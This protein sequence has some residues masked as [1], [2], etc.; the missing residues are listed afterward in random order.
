MSAILGLSMDKKVGL[1]QIFFLIAL[2]IL[3]AAYRDT[4]SGMIE[5]WT[6][7]E[8]YAH[9]FLIYPITLYLIWRR[10]KELAMVPKYWDW[11]ALVFVPFVGVA[12][13]LSDVV[14]VVVVKQ[15]AFTAM[16]PLLVWLVFGWQVLWC[17]AFPLAFLVFA[18][19]MGEGLITPLMNFTAMFT[20][21]LVKWSG[22]PIYAEGTFFSLPSGDWSVVEGCS[23]VRYLIASVTMG[24]LFAYLNYKSLTRRLAFI[25]F[26]IVL[27]II[28]NGLRAYMIVMIAHLSEMKLA[29][30]VDHLIYGWVF[31][32]FIMLLMFWIG[33]YWREEAPETQVDPDQ[34][35]LQNQHKQQSGYLHIVLMLT[36]ILIW[37]YLSH[38]IE[39][40]QGD[41]V[42]PAR[43]ELA[44]SYGGW[45]KTAPFTDWK[46]RYRAADSETI[47]FYK[48]DDALVGVYLAYY[49]TPRQDAELINSQNVM[50]IQKHPVWKQVGESKISL[51]IEP[52]KVIQTRLKSD[53]Q[54]LLIF[55]W[56]WI[57]GT[58]T[59]N[60]YLG[61]L[62][63]AYYQLTGEEQ[64][65]V[66]I[67]LFTEYEGGH[68]DRARQKLE[69]F[70]ASALPMV[71]DAIRHAGHSGNAK[72]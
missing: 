4:V 7:S 24:T 67:V 57:G 29:L 26:S 18:V 9:G 54:D 16:I 33:S 10:R 12:W 17:I 56:Y 40:S 62:L 66:G 23:G 36:L 37:P 50:I 71:K 47:G 8:T 65:S 68:K 55:D 19:P 51:G 44:Q 25:A 31:F 14:D 11:R 3:F 21:H 49:S 70:M 48:N 60:D 15:L 39:S 35:A 13:L 32:G 52:G 34:V 41:Q 63:E 59:T 46:P 28:A 72:N 61:K 42:A 2:F 69:D 64:P 53:R 58:Q 43:L 45:H 22:I 6:R 27:P 30:G 38:S 20:V 1:K 5:I